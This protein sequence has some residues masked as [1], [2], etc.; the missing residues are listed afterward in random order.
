MHKPGEVWKK[1]SLYRPAGDVE[2]SPLIGVW[3]HG[4]EI[5]ATMVGNG[6][7]VELGDFTWG[8]VY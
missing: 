7:V 1:T 8:F 2:L 6:K 5:L 3:I 4:E